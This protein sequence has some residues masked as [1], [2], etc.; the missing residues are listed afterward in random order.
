MTRKIIISCLLALGAVAC[1]AGGHVKAGPV[2]A[3]GHVAAHHR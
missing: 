1:R 2:A 3:G